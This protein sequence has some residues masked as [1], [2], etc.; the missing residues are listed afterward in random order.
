MTAQHQATGIQREL[1]DA[2][3]DLNAALQRAAEAAAAIGALARRVS[4]IGAL[5]D[6]LEAVVRSGRQQIGLGDI[7]TAPE[8]QASVTRPTLVVPGAAPAGWAPEP[9][10]SAEPGAPETA[11][12]AI[13]PAPGPAFAP[14]T[15]AEQRMSF[16]LTFE[17]QQGPLDL[18]VVDEAVG[19]HPAV[20]DVALLDYD[21]RRATLK[22]WI[23]AGVSPE[24]VQD[25]LRER[26]PAIFVDGDV[27]IVAL[28]DVA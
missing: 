14:A 12:A 15:P 27:T 2:V 3:T 23:D 7:L 5:F 28:E 26:A 21:G 10:P 24:T 20:R 19:E 1:D 11:P 25:E 17:S 9:Q 8:R 22:V 18:R 13:E 4:A 16:R 6:E